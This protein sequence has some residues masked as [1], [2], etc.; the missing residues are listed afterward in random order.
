MIIKAPL[1]EAINGQI[2]Y[3]FS[4]SSQYIAIAA[5][6]DDA[7]LPD[8]ASF[9]YR[10]SDEERE[11]AMKMVHFLLETG[12]R[13]II[14]DL[15]AVQN[16]FAGAADAVQLALNQEIK[17]TEQIN[18]LV[19]LATK[20]GDHTSNNFLQWFVME[21]VEEVDSMST[22]LSTIKHSGGNLLLVEEFV[23]RTASAAGAE[24][25]AAED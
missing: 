12:A 14:P 22:L 4:A 6:F 24:G 15:P 13:P 11:H 7:G 25:G 21:Q 16:E 2:R 10:Q 18:D 23:R 3:E 17:V 20:H 5:Y 9:F 1:V 8:L 19:S